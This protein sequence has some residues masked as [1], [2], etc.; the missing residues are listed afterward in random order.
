MTISRRDFV[1]A[2]MAA[3]AAVSIPSVLRAQTAPV[4][5][6][7]VLMVTKGDLSVFDP[8]NTTATIAYD[9]DQ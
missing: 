2:G 7:T 6:R 1:K 3:G 9:C 5:A 8:Y 4:D